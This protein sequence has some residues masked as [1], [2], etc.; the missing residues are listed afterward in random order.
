MS[1]LRY[2][3]AGVLA[4]LLVLLVVQQGRLQRAETAVQVEKAGRAADKEAA[5]VAAA[6]A[7]MDARAKEQRR[8]AAI[9]EAADAA[10]DDAARSRADARAS[11]DAAERLRQR[12]A[13]LA[14]RCG[15]SAGDPTAAT[16]GASAAGAGLVL[17]EL[18]QRADDRAGELAQYADQARIAGAACERAY[19]ALRE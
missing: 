9:Q 5:A 17:S 7:V 4:L 14:A 13:S 3:T 11:A 15:G 16:G 10:V 12:A 1:P 19:D 2:V 18:F 6:S 8:T